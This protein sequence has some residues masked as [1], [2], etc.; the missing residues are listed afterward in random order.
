MRGLGPG[1]LACGLALVASSGR[2][3]RA[4][5]GADDAK[6]ARAAPRVGAVQID[7][8]LDEA[9]W[10]AAPAF[11]DFVERTPKLRGIPPDRTEFR[12]LYDQEALYVGVLCEDSQP[13]AVQS[14]TLTRDSFS[15]FS[16][17]AI[18]LK[19]DTAHDHRS[20]IGLVLNTAGARIDYRGINESEFKVE[21]DG[22]WEGA[23]TRTP[24]GWS[25][26]FR[27]PW[28]TLG[29]DPDGEPG[30][31]GLNFSRDHARRNATYDWSLF[32]PPHIP[33]A[34]SRYGHLDGL[35]S[36]EAAAEESRASGF[37][38]VPY[39]LVAHR[40]GEP[41]WNAGLD[42]A[43][44]LGGRWRGQLTVN[45]DFAEVDVDDRVV[46]LTRFGLFLP[47]KRN[48]FLRDAELFAFGRPREA[49]LFHS[50]RVGLAAGAPIP[51]LGGAKLVGRPGR[52]LRVGLLGVV[53]GE[54]ADVG[55]TPESQTVGRALYELG[56]GSNAGAMVTHRHSLDVRDDRNTV[57]GLDGS[58][59]TTDQPL[60][61]SAAALGSITGAGAPQVGEREAFAG[62]VDIDWR[63][64]LIRPHLGYAAY[65]RDFRADLGFYPRVGV[66]QVTTWLD[67]E[68]RV[69]RAGIETV[70]FEG[71]GRWILDIDDGTRLNRSLGFNL[72][73]DWD[74]GWSAGISGD[75]TEETLLAPFSLPNGEEIPA[76]AYTMHTAF[77]HVGTPHTSPAGFDLSAS[78]GEFYGGTREHARASTYVRPG[79][80]LRLEVG[81]DASRVRFDGARKGFDAMVTNARIAIGFSPALGL[82][83]FGGWDHLADQL[84][85]QPRLRWTWAPGSDLF[86]VHREDIDTDA[87]AGRLRSTVAK[88]TYRWP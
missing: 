38:L 52:R 69:G 72:V 51:M 74:A 42:A 6:A 59:R 30:R 39:G 28:A 11:D 20:T 83:V 73:V 71:Y 35:L 44:L 13:E 57:V 81:G 4:H 64:E 47:E 26:E 62:H 78:A 60:V 19:L 7:G 53:T 50:R 32:P 77:A 17:D 87:G 8:R 76:G 48:F 61:I 1:A 41:D 70:L 2:D 21:W 68:P 25:A 46:N 63:G 15:I 33:I 29:V 18:S 65:Q 34:S 56:G 79:G 85:L 55:A 80:F 75:R 66:H 86:L 5:P 16:D 31:I 27:V 3:A 49:Q 14:E 45:T 88:L 67:V 54:E 43:G 37:E 23:A 24:A 22:L 58:W 36:E 9:A 82:D 10:A 40:S 12:V 84:L